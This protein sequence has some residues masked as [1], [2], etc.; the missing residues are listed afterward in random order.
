MVTRVRTGVTAAA[1][2][3][4]VRRGRQAGA[5][6][7]RLAGRPAR[8]W[9]RWA[10][11]STSRRS[12]TSLGPHGSAV[13][14]SRS[15]G[16]DPKAD[17]RPG[18]R[19]RCGASRAAG[20]AAA[21]K[22]FPGHGHTTGDSHDELPVLAQSRAALDSQDLPPFAA[23]IAAGRRPGDV[24]APRRPGDRPGRARHVLP[25]GH[26]R[27][28]ARRARVHRGR[29]HRRDEHGRRPRSGRPG[30]AAVRAL[31]AGNDLLLMP[32]D[33]A[34]ARDGIAG[35]AART[36]RCRGPA[37]SRRSPGS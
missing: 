7:G 24:R 33:L 19:R 11:T 31:N 23:G 32:P 2:R 28:A 21:L 10:S 29:D 13:I 3:D 9:P 16:A 37:W 15:F 35:R 18:R 1:L 17:R 20:V 5:D 6:R 36:A 12:P 4:G 26:D 34:G 30:E 14:G 22:H 8:S 27:R 25:Q